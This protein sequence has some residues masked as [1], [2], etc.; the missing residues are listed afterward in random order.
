[1]FLTMQ[2]IDAE[3]GSNVGHLKDPVTSNLMPELPS[4][5]DLPAG[6]GDPEGTETTEL[7][8]VSTIQD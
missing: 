1:M 7:L 3:H 2:G 5:P 8:W 4:H 6:L